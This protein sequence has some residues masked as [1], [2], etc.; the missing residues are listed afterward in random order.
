MPMGRTLRNLRV[1]SAAYRGARKLEGRVRVALEDGRIEE[2]IQ[3]VK[4]ER[5][6]S[7]RSTKHTII[8]RASITYKQDFWL[9]CNAATPPFWHYISTVPHFMATTQS[10]IRRIS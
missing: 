6:L 7:Q 3:G 9:I 4:L 2:D 10:E 5:V 8:A 1:G